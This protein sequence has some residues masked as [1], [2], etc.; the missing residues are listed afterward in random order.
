MVECFVCKSRTYRKRFKAFATF[1]GSIA[2][3]A[4]YGNVLWL[5][6]FILFVY[7]F[8]FYVRLGCLSSSF[9]L[10][11]VCARAF[12]HIS[13]NTLAQ[14]TPSLSSYLWKWVKNKSKKKKEFKSVGVRK[15]P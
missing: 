11:F 14:C 4:H 2:L 12:A 1:W 8:D 6:P 5:W 13:D 15:S 3:L 7:C 9:F 10:F